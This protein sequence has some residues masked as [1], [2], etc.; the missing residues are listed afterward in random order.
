MNPKPGYRFVWIWLLT[1]FLLPV[2]MAAESLEIAGQDGR[3]VLKFKQRDDK[4]KIEN[5]DGEILL[6]A[7]SR[8]DGK[9]RYKDLRNQVFVEVKDQ[10]SGFRLEG[11]DD[12][13]L[14]KIKRSP[15]RLKISQNEQNLLP[16]VLERT[17]PNLWTLSRNELIYAKVRHDPD[18]G[19]IKVQDDRDAARYLIKGATAPF[20]PLYG[21]LLIPNMEPRM[22]YVIM[23]ELWL[24]GW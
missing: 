20:S 6:Q 7:K 19:W 12:T 2:A 11:H 10:D 16:E 24:R 8:P 18:S 13:L 4:I 15:N 23:A 14:W 1:W 5:A 9:H 3:L 17:A 21:V 22:A